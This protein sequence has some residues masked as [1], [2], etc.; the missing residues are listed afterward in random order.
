M[1]ELVCKVGA[2]SA[3][4]T[5]YQD[6]D[7]LLA[8]HDDRIHYVYAQEVCDARVGGRVPVERSGLRVDALGLSQ[9]YIE[10]ISQFRFERVSR[11]EIKRVLLSDLS[12]E[13]LSNTP[14]AKGERIDVVEYVRRRL[15]HSKTNNNGGKA[16]FGTEGAEVWYGGNTRVNTANLT[17][18]W[19]EIERLTPERKVDHGRYPNLDFRKHLVL[20][21]NNFSAARGSAMTATEDNNTDP[22]NPVIVRKRAMFVD[23]DATLTTQESTDTRDR[24]TEVKLSREFIEATIV[25]TR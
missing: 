16:M 12:E 1:A 8:F 24:T 11:T 10:T 15:A 2:V 3:D 9:F 17:T 19:N 6:G 22:D 23:I 25:E 18:I 7:V 4:L 13:T 20:R 21:V 14:N 5:S